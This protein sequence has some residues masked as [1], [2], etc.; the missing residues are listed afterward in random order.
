MTWWMFRQANLS[1]DLQHD[2]RRAYYAAAGDAELHQRELAHILRQLNDRQ[3]Q[4]VVFKGAALAYSVYPDPACRTMG[5]I[6]LWTAGEDIE[7]ARQ[8]LRAASGV[9]GLVDV[10]ASQSL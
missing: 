4:V 3:I 9:N 8:A 10:S 1:G 5:D 2:L 6:D 7:R